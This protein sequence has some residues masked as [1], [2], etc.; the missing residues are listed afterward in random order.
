MGITQHTATVV[1]A[2]TRSLVLL[3]LLAGTAE[4]GLVTEIG[5]GWKDFNTTS[6]LMRSD[7]QKA[8]VIDPEFPKNP[9][10]SHPYSC[11]GDNPVF[12]GWPLAWEFNNGNT[13]VGW[14]H[15]SQWFDGRG[16]LHFDC[17]CVSHKFDWKQ[18]RRRRGK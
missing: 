7:C 16:E 4:A 1:R 12:I 13:R 9:R 17:L 11:G 6:Y 5:G 8:V 3:A 14:F 15:Q 10:G 18:I 2:I